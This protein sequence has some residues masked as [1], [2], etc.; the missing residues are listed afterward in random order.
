MAKLIRRDT[1]ESIEFTESLFYSDEFNWAKVTHNQKYTLDGTLIVQTATRKAGR[2]VTLTAP[3]DM[4]WLTREQV[5]RLQIWCE[6]E[7]LKLWYER[8]VKGVNTQTLVSFNNANSPIDAK[9]VKGFN[10]PESDDEFT[11]KISLI[12]MQNV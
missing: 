4:A 8:L 6:V 7:G 5:E 10:S 9:P 1:G 12:E 2:P 11:A 3:D